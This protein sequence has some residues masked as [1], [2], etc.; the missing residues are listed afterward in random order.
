MRTRSGLYLTLFF[1]LCLAVAAPVQATVIGPYTADYRTA[2]LY[3]F[4]GDSSATTVVD[5]GGS[6]V[7]HHLGIGSAVTPGVSGFA[8]FGNAVDMSAGGADAYTRTANTSPTPHWTADY[9]AFTW[10]AMINVSTITT[11]GNSQ[12]IMVRQD[13]LAGFSQFRISEDGQ[14]SLGWRNTANTAHYGIG[15]AIPTTGANAFVANEWFHVAVTYN[16]DETGTDNVSFYWTRVA[17]SATEA[18]L[19]GTATLNQDLVNVNYYTN[20]GNKLGSNS[21]LMGSLDEVRIS[22]IARGADDFIFTVPEPATMGLLAVG[23]LGVLF[24]RKQ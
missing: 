24:R 16:G 7:L 1:G 23:G 17:D 13:A 21:P 9:G 3:H 22:T 15:A 4:D 14:V 18:N 6:S 8:G 19:I 10:E 2:H 5:V 11:P 20:F 12:L